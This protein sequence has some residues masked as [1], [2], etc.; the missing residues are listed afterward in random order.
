F[1]S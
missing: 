1:G